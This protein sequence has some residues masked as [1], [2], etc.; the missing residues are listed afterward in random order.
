MEA[1]DNVLNFSQ[2]KTKEELG[3]DRM[4]F[5]GIVKNIEIVGEAAYSREEIDSI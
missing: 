5:Y 1:I 2:G 4:R 3:A